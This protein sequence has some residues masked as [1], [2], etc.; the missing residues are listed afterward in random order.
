MANAKLTFRMARSRS[1]RHRRKPSR[2]R[3]KYYA[4]V[5]LLAAAVGGVGVY[6][7]QDAWRSYQARKMAGGVDALL[8]EGKVREALLRGQSALRL[9]PEEPEVL[10]R[11]AQVLEATGSATALGFHDKLAGAGAARPQDRE[12][13]LRAAMRFGQKSVAQR[14]AEDLAK[15]GDAGFRHLVTAEAMLGRGDRAGAERELRAVAAASGAA[16]ESRLLVAQLMAAEE[17]PERRAEALQ[18]LHEVSLQDGKVAVEAM[19]SALTTGLVPPGEL[20]VWADRLEA[21]PQANERTFLLVQSARLQSA[22]GS[23]AELVEQVMTRF[24]DL[25]VERRTEALLWLNGIGEHERSLALVSSGEALSHADAYVAWLDA[26]AGR[27][28][29]KR[30]EASLTSDKI[31]LQG[32]TAEMFRARAARMTGKEGAA[33]QGYQRAI[34]AALS[35][36]RQL[37]AAMNFLAADGQLPLL[38]ETLVAALS[39]PATSSA[40][41]QGLVAVEKGG[42]EAGKMRDLHVM[43]RDRLPDNADVRGDLIYYDLILGGTGL[44]GE[45]WQMSEAEPENFA[46]R[47]VYALALLREGLADKAVAVFDGLSVRSDRITPEQKVVVISVL[48]ANGRMDQAQAMAMTLDGNGLTREEVEMV[49]GYL[50]AGGGAAAERE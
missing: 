19:G 20:T 34:N 3:W 1:S 2:R 43:L 16:G 46:R 23:R 49:N 30:V 50:Q 25:P 33:R 17:S 37:G 26:L 7:G 42:R 47:A 45:A 4:A 40:A 29:W 41:E 14:V 32:T 10:R 24:A 36:P 5:L 11:M 13:H 35:D 39:Q 18:M 9:N 12:N 21:H 6:F 28:D 27:G 15:A 31:P 48:A 22:P 38:R 44:T 8:A